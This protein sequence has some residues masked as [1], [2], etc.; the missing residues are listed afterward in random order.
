MDLMPILQFLIYFV[1]IFAI[2]AY[3]I[4]DG[5][6]LGVG[7]LHLFAR[8]DQ[9]RRVMINSIGPVWDGNTTWIVI[10]GGV[11][12]AGFPKVF[13]ILLSNLYTPIMLMLFGFMIRAAS[14]EFRGKRPGKTWHRIWDT[15][16]FCSSL[17]LA[18]VVGVLLGNLIQGFSL[19][20]KGE[21]VGGFRTLLKPYPLVISLFGLATFMMHGSLYLL[22]K[23]EGSLHQHFRKWALR[24]LIIFLF[25]W[26]IATLYTLAAVPRMVM[27]FSHHPALGLFVLASF[28]SILGIPW[29]LR[30]KYDGWAFICSCLS[31]IFLLILF[32][33]GTF[34]YL[35][36]STLDPEHASLT[37]FNSSASKIALIA[38]VTI[39]L[40]GIPLS[41]FYA[42]YVFKVFKGK[43]KL[44]NTSY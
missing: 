26:L 1:F 39:S 9:E 44:D 6:D 40:T 18:L 34:P 16:F 37:L 12:L 22:M 42:S 33:I 14:I 5:F 15:A 38:L 19:N 35:A 17:I 24:L 11:L 41:F 8:N 30:K 23:T 31:I 10:G 43:V 25:F 28:A 21:L 36:Y 27:L 4:L 29:S 20:A 7:C 3:A 13:S 2:A 32:M